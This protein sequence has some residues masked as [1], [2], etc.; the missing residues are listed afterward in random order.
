M[1][2][3]VTPHFCATMSEPGALSTPRLWSTLYERI[4]M[5]KRSGPKPV[6]PID[7]LMAR[8][9][10][11]PG[12]LATPCWISTYVP[13]R[14]GYAMVTT[15]GRHAPAHRCSYEHFIGP[16][17]D[18]LELDHLCRVRACV[19][20]LHLE[21]VTRAENLRRGMSPAAI[22]VRTNMCKRGH[23]LDDAYLKNGGRACRTCS[24]EYG[25]ARMLINR[26]TCVDCGGQTNK[27]TAK[28]CRPCQLALWAVGRGQ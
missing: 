19:N 27:Q 4:D 18:G 10:E 20:P 24:H 1:K 15:D 5:A 17:P 28:R 16:I 2:A 6:A 21:P 26:G 8:V 14:D 13:G 12:P 7:R 9:T 25:M 22:A 3:Q 23:S 11:T